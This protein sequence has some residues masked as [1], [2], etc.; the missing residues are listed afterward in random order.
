MG[1]HMGIS[2]VGYNLYPDF[3]R[4]MFEGRHPLPERVGRLCNRV[5]LGRLVLDQWRGPTLMKWES[6]EPLLH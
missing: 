5:W 4:G 3:L 6:D 2:M 1:M